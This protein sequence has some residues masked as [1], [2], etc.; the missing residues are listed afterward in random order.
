MPGRTKGLCI[1]CYDR[2]VKRKIYASKPK[3]EIKPCVRC[4]TPGGICFVRKDAAKVVPWRSKTGLCMA[5]NNADTAKARA[6]ARKVHPCRYCGTPGGRTLKRSGM[7]QRIG[8]MC[9]KCYERARSLAL[10]EKREREREREDVQVRIRLAH[11]HRKAAYFKAKMKE[12]LSPTEQ[13]ISEYEAIL[14]RWGK[15]EWFAVPKKNRKAV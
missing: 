9:R 11:C 7:P 13:A 4:K 2:G 6:I 8:G 10:R 12:S 3:R 14:R 5:C 15:S 1:G